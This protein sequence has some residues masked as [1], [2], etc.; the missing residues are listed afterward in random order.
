M[1]LKGF[2]SSL[3][4]NGFATIALL[5]F[6]VMFVA[7]VVWTMTRPKQEMDRLARLWEDDD[8]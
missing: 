6:F 3:G 7:I 8:A 1:G 2:M 4:M 5:A